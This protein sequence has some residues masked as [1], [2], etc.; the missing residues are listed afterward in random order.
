MTNKMSIFGGRPIEVESHLCAITVDEEHKT[1][2]FT[3]LGSR[4]TIMRGGDDDCM[5]FSVREASLLA[6]ALLTLVS[7]MKK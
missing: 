6:N 1:V 5:D 4:I 3:G 2:V 7:S